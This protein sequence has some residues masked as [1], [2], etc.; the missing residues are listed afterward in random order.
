MEHTEHSTA[1]AIPPVGTRVGIEDGVVRIEEIVGNTLR[2][3]HER[4]KRVWIIT[5]QDFQER[6]AKI[7]GARRE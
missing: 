3:K 6:M 1:S 2:I 4:T 5:K 7:T